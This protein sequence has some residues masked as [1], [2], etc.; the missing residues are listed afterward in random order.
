[1][2]IVIKIG[3]NV[4]TSDQGIIQEQ[5]I[6]RLSE[7]IF[8]LLENGNE[9]ILLSSGAVAFGKAR[10]SDIN[11]VHNNQ[12]WAAIGQPYLMGLY[13]KFAEKY[14]VKV[15]QL[16]I[17]RSELTQKDRYFNFVETLE[18][19]LRAKILPI[20]NGNDVISMSDLVAKDNDMLAAM[21][22]VAVKADKLLIL[23]NQEGFF[24]ANPLID[25]NAKLIKEVKNVDFELEKLCVGPKS[26]GGTGG[27]LS[28]IRAAKQA[29]SAGV[30]TLIV[31][32][33]Q[34]GVLKKALSESYI[35]TKFAAL[36]HKELNLQQRWLVAA[37]C[38]GQL[39]ID[40]GAVDALRRSKSLLFPGII[41]SRGI[42]D[43]GEIVEVVSKSG[44]AVAYG[45]TN[46]D[47]KIIEEKINSR[48]ID[49]QRQT[50]DKEV[51]HSDHMTVLHP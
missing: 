43:K 46:Y 1:M 48:K 2:R 49:G 17:L 12:I 39:V 22:A 20:I 37:K 11:T 47:Y 30:E 41:T 28:K 38:F 31:D 40:D 24:S 51:I 34:K 25:K 33:R 13:G 23:T 27:M 16:L 6:E 45:K 8:D 10:L 50:L 4:L 9:I 42:Y 18:D 32:G 36:N 19:M 15:G 29:V 7:E 3:T 26:S 5:S 35:G 14:G 21:I 44:Q